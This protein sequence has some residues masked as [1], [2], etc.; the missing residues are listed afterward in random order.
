MA[1]KDDFSVAGLSPGGKMGLNLGGKKKPPRFL[2]YV[3]VFGS[4]EQFLTEVI[5]ACQEL[6]N[7]YSP[8]IFGR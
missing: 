5:H 6:G 1:N 4:D 7:V 8:R 3:R 2:K